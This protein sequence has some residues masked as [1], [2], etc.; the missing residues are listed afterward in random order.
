MGTAGAYDCA[1]SN[2][3]LEVSLLELE[4]PVTSPFPM[5]PRPF[6]CEEDCAN[7]HHDMI[8]SEWQAMHTK[9]ET[10]DA[11]HHRTCKTQDKCRCLKQL[12]ESF[13]KEFQCDR[14]GCHQRFN[15]GEI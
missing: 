5:V 2:C 11:W 9:I 6:Y 12:K 3:F 4:A 1:N 8:K 13:D 7:T 15:I 14:E 10:F